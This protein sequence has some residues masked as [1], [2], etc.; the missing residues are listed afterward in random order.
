MIC[1]SCG[2]ECHAN[3]YPEFIFI[4]KDNCICEEC[5]IDWEEINGKIQLREGV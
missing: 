5:S 2:N 3:K 1:T 4:D